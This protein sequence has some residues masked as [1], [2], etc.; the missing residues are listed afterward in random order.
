MALILM[1]AMSMSRLSRLL[2]FPVF[3]EAPP[4][5]DFSVVNVFSGLNPGDFSNERRTLAPDT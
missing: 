1:R 4:V 5:S 2:E 3:V